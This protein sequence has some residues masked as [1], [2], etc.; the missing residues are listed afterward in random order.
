MRILLD[1]NFLIDIV[2]FR[3]NLEDLADL[4]GS[5]ELAAPSPVE[6]EL[7]KISEAHS[8]AS[9]YA[10]AAI[11]LLRVNNVKILQSE[12]LADNAMLKLAGKDAL[13]ATNDIELRKRL[14]S[15]GHRVIY[16]KS[17]KHLTIG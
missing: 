2:R 15:L 13:V 8:Q 4:I 7:L 5:Y 6:K 17:K 1:T 3:I 9:R 16:L 12:G 14:M 11:N 10:R